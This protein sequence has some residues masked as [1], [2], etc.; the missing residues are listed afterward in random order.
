MGYAGYRRVKRLFHALQIISIFEE[1]SRIDSCH[2]S[3][4]VKWRTLGAGDERALESL[5]NGRRPE[6]FVAV[7]RV[8]RD[9]LAGRDG[10]LRVLESQP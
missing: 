4:Y 9:E 3:R 5:A 10:A 1:I 2:V 7:R 8:E 6:H